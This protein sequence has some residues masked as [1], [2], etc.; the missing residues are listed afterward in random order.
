MSR[1]GPS[2]ALPQ[3]PG[4]SQRLLLISAS[5]SMAMLERP[6]TRGMWISL[7]VYLVL[8][9]VIDL[10]RS[11]LQKPGPHLPWYQTAWSEHVRIHYSVEAG[12]FDRTLVAHGGSLM[13]RRRVV[14]LGARDAVAIAA[15]ASI[16]KRCLDASYPNCSCI[17]RC[18]RRSCTR[19]PRPHRQTVVT[20]AH[21]RATPLAKLQPEPGA[22]VHR[23]RIAQALNAVYVSN[24]PRDARVDL[25]LEVAATSA[26][27]FATLCCYH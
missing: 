4:R 9:H 12:V 21:A 1:R 10:P 13:R 6:L 19:E 24:S 16:G 11:S 2:T 5:R 26:V 3:C 8:L 25:A 23:F 15:D 18:F 17:W 22:P 14:A 27:G 20:A 7:R